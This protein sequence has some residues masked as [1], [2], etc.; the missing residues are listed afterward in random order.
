MTQRKCR[1]QSKYCIRLSSLF[2]YICLLFYGSSVIHTSEFYENKTEIVATAKPTVTHLSHLRLVVYGPYGATRNS[3]ER[4]IECRVADLKIIVAP[5]SATCGVCSPSSTPAS[6]CPSGR[7]APSSG[8]CGAS[9][10]CCGLCRG[11]GPVGLYLC[12][13]WQKE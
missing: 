5:F 11:R 9:C 2:T 1:M 7:G 10:C 13:G 3:V 4:W 6:S 12:K 8:T